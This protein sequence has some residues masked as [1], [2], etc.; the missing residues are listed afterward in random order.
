VI[1]KIP[2]RQVFIFVIWD[3]FFRCGLAAR[4]WQNPNGQN[5]NLKNGADE[6]PGFLIWI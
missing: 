2:K 4:G 5:Q 3:S 6:K 1:F